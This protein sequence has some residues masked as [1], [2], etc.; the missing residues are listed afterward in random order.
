MQNTS[1]VIEIDKYIET[2]IENKINQLLDSLPQNINVNTPK[3]IHEYT[4]GEL[5][6]GT[7]L[8]V[9]EIINEWTVL[10]TNRKYLST[11]EYFKQMFDIF[12]KSDRK[13][14]VGIVL[15]I[16]SFIIYFIDGA[17]I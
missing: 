11:K 10:N 4:I 2:N 13:I 3:M 14:F 17:S 7:I 8:T 9:V 12:L 1:N 16:L 5:Y 6:N 15:V